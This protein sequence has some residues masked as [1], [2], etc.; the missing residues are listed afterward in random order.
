M[1]RPGQRIQLA[2]SAAAT[3]VRVFYPS[4]RLMEN[5]RLASVKG[6]SVQVSAEVHS[7]RPPR[8]GASDTRPARFPAGKTTQRV[9]KPFEP[10]EPRMRGRSLQ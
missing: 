1:V 4:I 8:Y 10:E 9:E 2:D 5:H 7:G 3:D 6:R